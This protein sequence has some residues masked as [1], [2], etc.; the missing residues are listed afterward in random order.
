VKSAYKSTGL[1]ALTVAAALAGCASNDPYQNTK[2]GAVVGA[3]AGTVIA[4]QV[5]HSDKGRVAGALIG[6]ALGG[7]LG[8]S[9]DQQAHAL[10][11][12]LGPAAFRYQGVTMDQPNDRS[13]QLD[14]PAKVAFNGT[15]TALK[16]N[17][18]ST[19]RRLADHLMRYPDSTVHVIGHA[20]SSGSDTANLRVSRKRADLV[21]NYLEERGVDPAR[22]IVEARGEEQP[23][24]SNATAKGRELN[25]RV[26]ILIVR[27][28][29]HGDAANP[30]S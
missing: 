2:T 23:R 29:Q 25:R 17:F 14:V 7:A 5:A 15:S 20:D 24:A 3:V 1:I 12:D 30:N 4:N 10:R 21:A 11:S 18:E 9:M 8:Y 28:N 6:A 19:L 16:P 26:E 22:I 13:I 27:N